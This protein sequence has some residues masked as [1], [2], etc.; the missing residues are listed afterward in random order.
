MKKKTGD[1]IGDEIEW[2]QAEMSFMREVEKL[3]L[4]CKY[5]TCSK[6]QRETPD[7]PL[8]ERYCNLPEEPYCDGGKSMLLCIRVQSNSRLHGYNQHYETRDLRRDF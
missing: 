1:K 2:G 5:R 8:K 4:S 6:R 3:T 7:L